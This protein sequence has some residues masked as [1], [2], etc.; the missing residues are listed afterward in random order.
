MRNLLVQMLIA[1][2]YLIVGICATIFGGIIG[3]L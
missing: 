1:I 3:G 2:A